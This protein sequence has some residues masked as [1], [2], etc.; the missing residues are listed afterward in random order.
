M[1][2]FVAAIFVSL[3]L[4]LSLAAQSGTADAGRPS[5]A[6]GPSFRANKEQVA[7]AQRN[8]SL[9]ET[10]KMD[11]ATRTA[12]RSYQSQNGLRPNGK[13][14][15]ATL[16]KMGIALTDAQKSI[17]VATDSFPSVK[18]NGK[19]GP[20][21]RATKEQVGQAQRLLKQRGLYA[22]GETGKLDDQTR[23]AIRGFQ[24]KVGMKATGT[25]N[26]KTLEKMGIGLTERQASNSQGSPQ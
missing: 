10:G 6:R 1:N 9:A 14:N 4:S 12:L 22:G 7:K 20:V 13:L 19:R 5:G 11:D 18:G 3:L 2:R 24:E 16:E 17:P 25:L 26:P 8:L 23:A 15:R 21:F